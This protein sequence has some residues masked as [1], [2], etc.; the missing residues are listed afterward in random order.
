MMVKGVFEYV[1]RDT[2]D[3]LMVVAM[4][5]LSVLD[6]V[7]VLELTGALAFFTVFISFA[8]FRIGY[9]KWRFKK[10]QDGAD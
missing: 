7:T 9:W 2:V 3:V 8:V 1:L 4:I 10:L 5:I 6:F